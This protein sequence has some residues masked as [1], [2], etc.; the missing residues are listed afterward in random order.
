[1]KNRYKR[2]SKLKLVPYFETN[3]IIHSNPNYHCF[4]CQNFRHQHLF[5]D[6]DSYHCPCKHRTSYMAF[7]V[8]HSHNVPLCKIYK[9][10]FNTNSGAGFT[11]S[12]SGRG[13]SALFVWSTSIPCSNGSKSG[14]P[15]SKAEYQ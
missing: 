13:F 1:M 5:K 11:A 4:H 9:I 14:G 2:L 7:G 6:Y 12:G 10:S 15:I 3:T 8:L